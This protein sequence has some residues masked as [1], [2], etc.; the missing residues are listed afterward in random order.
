MGTLIHSCLI[1]VSNSG[2]LNH[3]HLGYFSFSLSEAYLLVLG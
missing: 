2:T 1:V 3:I